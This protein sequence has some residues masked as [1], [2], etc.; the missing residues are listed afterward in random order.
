MWFPHI[1]IDLV[2]VLDIV[3]LYFLAIRFRWYAIVCRSY[4][5]VAIKIWFRYDI[6]LEI[7]LDVVS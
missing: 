3:I 6:N 5:D 7:L 1:E 4:S 2:F